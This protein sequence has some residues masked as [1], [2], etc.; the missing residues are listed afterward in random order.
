VDLET[1][2][3]LTLGDVDD[4]AAGSAD[5]RLHHVQDAHEGR[6]RDR[7]QY[8]PVPLTTANPVSAMMTRSSRNDWC[9]M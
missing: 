1:A 8:A 3:E 4:V 2:R 6:S 5:R 7:A 9:S